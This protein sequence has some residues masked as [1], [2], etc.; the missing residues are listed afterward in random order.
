MPGQSAGGACDGI[1]G[2]KQV[3]DVSDGADRGG[4]T[5]APNSSGFVNVGALAMYYEL[6]G[7]GEP[8]V[9]LHGAMGTI[10]SCFGGLLPVLARHFQVIAVELQGHGRTRDVDRPLTYEGMAAD[11]AM[12]LEALSIERAH[13]VGYSMGGVLKPSQDETRRSRHKGE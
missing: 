3:L 11:T 9:L 8:V 10:E 6:H 1:T 2:S 5:A 13:F 7:K 12:L 4:P